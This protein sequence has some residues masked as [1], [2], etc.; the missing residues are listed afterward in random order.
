MTSF[1][2]IVVPL[3]PETAKALH[4][5]AIIERREPKLQASW[6]I[7]RALI[8]RGLLHQ[9]TPPAQKADDNSSKLS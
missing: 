9:N 1:V 4:S 2:K 6:L 8:K 3:S 5:L 7:E